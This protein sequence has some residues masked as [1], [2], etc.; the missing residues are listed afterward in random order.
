MI[1]F[2]NDARAM[3]REIAR[4]LKPGGKVVIGLIDAGG[5]SWTFALG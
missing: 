3:L 1:C 2:V 5:W 4:V